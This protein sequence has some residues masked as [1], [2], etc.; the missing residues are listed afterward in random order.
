MSKQQAT[1]ET[2]AAAKATLLDI[3]FMRRYGVSTPTVLVGFA[4]DDYDARDAF[5]KVVCQHPGL[6]AA[7]P[8]QHELLATFTEWARQVAARE[9]VPRAIRSAAAGLAQDGKLLLAKA[10]NNPV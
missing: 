9:D 2:Q 8:E 4:Q 3:G 5:V 6:I 1:T 10:T 7:A